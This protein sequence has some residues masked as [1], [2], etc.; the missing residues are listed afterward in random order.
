VFKAQ[1]RHPV[2]ISV[3]IDGAEVSVEA[4][5]LQEAEAALKLAKRFHSAHP[6]VKVKPQS[7]VK[8]K[9]KVSKKPY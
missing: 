3:V 9:V 7:Q 6:A 8:A 2:K 1:E 4:A 5:D